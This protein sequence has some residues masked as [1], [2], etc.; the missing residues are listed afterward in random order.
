M[1]EGAESTCSN[2]AKGAALFTLPVEGAGFGSEKVA[3][4]FLVVP[5][6]L[7][8]VAAGEP[9]CVVL[10]AGI[11]I[12]AAGELFTAGGAWN[13][14][15][16]TKMILCFCGFCGSE[17]SCGPTVTVAGFALRVVIGVPAESRL[18]TA[19]AVLPPSGEPSLL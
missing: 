13:G 7:T 1:F 15:I 18:Y 9:S 11:L 2:G 19:G 5:P 4:A 17:A 16:G 14:V 10:A 6:G 3:G 12:G 8:V